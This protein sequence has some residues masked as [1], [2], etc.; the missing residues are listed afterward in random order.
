MTEELFVTNFPPDTTEEQLRDLFAQQGPVLEVN[1]AQEEKSGWPYALIR[2]GSEKLA[3]KAY[4]TLNGYRIG[5]HRLAVS[6]LNADVTKELTSKHR[7]AMEEI[8]TALGE[9]DEIPLRQ[10]E[11]I[12]RLC[13]ATFAQAI[14][15]EALELDAGSGLMT[16]DTSQRRTR[17]GVFFYL[18]RYRMSPAVRRIVYNRKGKMPAP[19]EPVA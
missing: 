14:V 18:A 6:N 9:R 4:N 13:G 10:I 8:V 11:A 7:R 5:D 3:T 12:I 19:A 1:M 16:S 2:M 15:E 17:G